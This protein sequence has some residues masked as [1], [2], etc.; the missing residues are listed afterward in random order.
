MRYINLLDRASRV[1]TRNCFLYN[2]TIIFAVPK[3]LMSKAIGPDAVN[4]KKLQDKLGK[5]VRIVEE[6]KGINGAEKFISDVITP[7]KF[8]SLEVAEKEIVITAGGTQNKAAL[9][10]RNKRRL[11][12]LKTI[13]ES[14]FNLGLRIA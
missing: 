2:N 12:E 8:R 10:G 11:I 4:I 5:R 1:K 14:V 6:P 3:F 13:V 9:I 7:V